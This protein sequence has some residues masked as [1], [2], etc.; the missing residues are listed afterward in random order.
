MSY[1]ITPVDNFQKEAKRLIKKYPSLKNEI[2]ALNDILEENP[3]Q[4]KALG[5]NCY[6]IRIS[7]KSKNKGKSAGARIITCVFAVDE[8]VFLLSI[9]DKSEKA[10]I[11]DNDIKKLIAGIF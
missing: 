6:K 2:A 7:I 3:V 8:E 1:K 10:S 11:S 5:N 9:Y 4:G